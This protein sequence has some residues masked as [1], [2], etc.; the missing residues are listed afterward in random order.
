MTSDPDQVVLALLSRNLLDYDASMNLVPGLAE[1]VLPDPAHKVYTVRLRGDARWEDGT[2]VTSEDVAYTIRAL[3]DPKTPSLNRR[4]FF[5]GFER[6]DVVDVRTARVVF[7]SASANRLDA[8]NL[9]LLP[10]TRYKG[11]DIATNAANRAPLANGPYR[12]AR[13]D[14]GQSL[15]LVRNTQYFGEKPPAE[16]VLF[17]IAPDA[18]SAFQ[19]LRTGELDES[20][21]DF[22]QKKR[23]DAESAAN[24]RNRSVVFPGLGYTYIGWNNRLALFSDPHVRRALT[25]LID[26]VAIAS[27][28]Y[29][30]LAR[31]A[32]GPLP[33]G[34]WPHDST[35]QPW[36]YDPPAAE[37]ALDRAGF[38]RGPDGVRTR[39]GARF[40]FHLSFGSGSDRQRQIA[41]FVQQAYRKA[42]IE[43]TLSPMEWATFTTKVDAGEF[44]A[45]ALSMSLD[46]NPDLSLN[47]HSAQIPPTGLNSVYY[48]N[49][50]ADAL[51]D[52]LKT[53][54]DR[55][56]AIALYAEL[57]RLIHEDEPV[58]FLHDVTVTWG[59]NRRLENVST[60]PYG[61]F[62]FWPG[63]T[64][65]RP[66]RVKAPI[67]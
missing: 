8:F 15:E 36:P 40:A 64:S 66:T 4:G 45:C 59:V 49:P 24:A 13:W 57:Q 27:A 33:S 65:W 46:P 39:A 23:L 26:R 20:R 58:T 3:M 61:L 63:G 19:A 50:R 32:N 7:Q 6:V 41:E 37:A 44:E 31:P 47:W 51:M 2:P 42:G 14:S 67:S 16:R 21:L 52:E 22:E 12:L 53:T 18:S 11:T 48:K 43:M 54:F 30:G 9:P 25:Q 38:R 5:E 62:L 56:R 35:L 34:L 17:R 10:S 29:G 60:S 55:P 1:S 28:L